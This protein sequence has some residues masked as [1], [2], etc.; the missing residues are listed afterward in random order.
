VHLAAGTILPFGSRLPV[1]AVLLDVAPWQLP[2]AFQRTPAARFG[3]R[4]RLGLLR[5]ARFVVAGTQAVGGIAER[6][7]HIPAATLRTVPFAAR[8]AFLAATSRGA[9]RGA[10]ATA[11]RERLGLPDRYLSWS[12]RH[13]ARQ[14]RPTLLRALRILADTGRP[15]TLDE[16]TPWP[17]RILVVEATPGDRAAVARA[18]ARADLGDAFAYAPALD[19]ERLATLVA[20]GRAAIAPV[21]SEAAGLATIE[22]LACR[23]PVVASGVGA[24][25]ELVGRA[26]ILVPPRAPERLAEA[27]RTIVTDDALHDGLAKEARNRTESHARSW[28]DV[29]DDMRRLFAEAVA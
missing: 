21:V 25:P 13:D 6:R 14:D 24:L 22:A 10:K 28:R 7:L 15:T 11:E 17:P 2:G 1:V 16:A 26:G 18:A 29:R 20:A 8:D 23:V 4:L 5:E 12:A 9:T 19:A 27:L 3:A